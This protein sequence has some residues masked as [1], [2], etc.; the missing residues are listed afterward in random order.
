MLPD[1]GTL[2][3]DII[4]RNMLV[5]ILFASL[6]CRPGDIMMTTEMDDQPM[7]YLTYGDV[8]LSLVGDTEDIES[9]EARVKIRNEKLHK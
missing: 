4:V 8:L 6:Q 2:N 1:D 9:L 3:W 7:P 5:L